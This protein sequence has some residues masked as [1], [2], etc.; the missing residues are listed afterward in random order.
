MTKT[1]IC[2]L[3][4]D[5]K[6]SSVTA[7]PRIMLLLPPV[8]NFYCMFPDLCFPIQVAPYERPALSKAYLFPECE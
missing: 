2:M 4:S 6:F 5:L 8:I 3:L 7:V 1:F